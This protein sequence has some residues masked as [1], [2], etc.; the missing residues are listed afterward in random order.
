MITIART[1]QART[2][3]TMVVVVT[4]LSVAVP[5]LD[6]GR[7]PGA[8]ALSEPG[9]ATGHVDHHHAICLQHSVTAWSPAVGTDLPSQRFVRQ[10]DSPCRAIVHPVE[11]IPSLHHPR[12]PPLV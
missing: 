10:A 5:L 2:A 6:Q 1:L 11:S 4:V 12:A 9:E 3:A 8:L 7:D